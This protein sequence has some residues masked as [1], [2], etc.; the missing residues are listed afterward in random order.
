MGPASNPTR[1]RC[2]NC[3]ES[4]N[5]VLSPC[6]GFLPADHR[7]LLRFLR[8]SLGFALSHMPKLGIFHKGIHTGQGAH[9]KPRHA[10]PISFANEIIFRKCKNRTKEEICPTHMALGSGPVLSGQRREVQK[11]F[12]IIVQRR[13]SEMHQRTR[14][15]GRFP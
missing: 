15:I 3:F 12:K 14:E 1:I 8:I 9:Q 4:S 7:S 11:F 2:L 5:N 10:I 6:T 13:P